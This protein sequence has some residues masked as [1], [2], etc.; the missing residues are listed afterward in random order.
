[1]EK[2]SDGVRAK[3][4]GGLHHVALEVRDLD[5]AIRFYTEVLGLELRH[6]WMRGD[7]RRSM[8]EIGGGSF[9]EIFEA[10]PEDERGVGRFVHLAFTCEDI[11]AAIER[12]R[13]AGCEITV[14]PG[15]VTVVATPPIYARNAFFKGPDGELI[16]L[17][18]WD[19]A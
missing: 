2:W 18:S 4:V 19:S 5:G 12:V 9:F 17:F 15:P 10:S 1:M 3:V 14:E 16:E 13:T 6:T 11:E 8:L 7:S